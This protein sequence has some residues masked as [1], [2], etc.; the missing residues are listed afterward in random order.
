MNII[1]FITH[2]IL[3]VV[4]LA[5]SVAATTSSVV[6][7]GASVGVVAAAASSVVASAAITT[8]SVIR[9]GRL[10]GRRLRRS[11]LVLG[12][13][14]IHGVEHLL[15][16]L[17]RSS[18]CDAAR[19]EIKLG[20]VDEVLEVNARSEDDVHAGDVLGCER[21]A[22]LGTDTRERD[23]EVAELVEQNLLALK[24][25]LHQTA[26][27]VG[28]HA[29]HLSALVSA[30]LGNVVHKLSEGH[31]LL[32]LSP[33]VRLGFLVLLHLVLKHK[34]RIIYHVIAHRRYGTWYLHSTSMCLC[35]AGVKQ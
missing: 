3:F 17:E 19:H 10:L 1:N 24:Q 27:H 34:N 13:S 5:S 31:H 4:V 8:W 14:K 26:A 35:P 9:V 22:V 21:L 7:A 2:S 15:L 29:L 25:L 6:A 16:G 11:S 23:P 32:H 30:V 18:L 33:G 12:G 28:E 20:V